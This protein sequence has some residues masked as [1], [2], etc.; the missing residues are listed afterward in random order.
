MTIFIAISLI[1]GFAMTSIPFLMIFAGGYFYVGV[2]SLWL[3]WTTH[4]ASRAEIV[5]EVE[6]L[7]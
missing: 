5:P 2:S 7:S 1:Y 3:M 4:N 6:L